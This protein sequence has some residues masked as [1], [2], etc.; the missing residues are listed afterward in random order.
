[1]KVPRLA[2]DGAKAWLGAL[3]GYA[4]LV[5][6]VWLPQ[7]V[8]SKGMVAIAVL[9][10]IAITA[11]WVVG[12]VAIGVTVQRGLIAAAFGVADIAMMHGFGSSEFQAA[13][14]LGQGRSLDGVTLAEVAS[15]REDGIWVR[16]TD[17][18]VR[19]DASEDFHYTSGG[20]SDGKGGVR[21][22]TSSRV[23]VAPVLLASSVTSE[24]PML[25]RDPSG[26]VWLW[27]CA[28]D[29]FALR[30]WDTQR[31]AVRGRLEPM[32]DHVVASLRKE[33]GPKVAAPIPGAGA[34]PAAPGAYEPTIAVEHD[35]MSL[36][37]EPWCVHL[38]RALDASAAKDQAQSTVLAI[39][40]S[41]P[42]WTVLFVFLVARTKPE[43][44]KR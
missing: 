37:A 7:L 13:L 6:A 33:I 5:A 28:G 25:R 19:S 35:G 18:R 24:E 11:V 14:A 32:E 30:D 22:S 34:I 42:F 17:A 2:V 8:A 31:Q 43:T 9:L 38:D 1:M 12:I 40:L 44:K 27:A 10:A 20:G 16:I 3:P 4:V 29:S 26:E 15:Q 41:V 39:G 23:S 21:S 36:P